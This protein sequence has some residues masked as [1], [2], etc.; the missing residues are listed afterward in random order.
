MDNGD[1][2]FF[3]NGNLSDILLGDTNPITRIRRIKVIDNSYCKTVWQY[4]LPPSLHGLGMGSVQELDNGNYSIYTYGSGLNNP[5]CSIIEITSEK[6]MVWK[7]TGNNNTAWYRAYKIPELHPEA[8][9]VIA[10]NYILID[11]NKVINISDN[12]LDFTIKNRSGYNTVSYTHLTLPT[13]A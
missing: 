5:E 13:K 8:F 9:S 4:D 1:L 12:S 3:D 10:E 2:L 7:A 6:E 11:S